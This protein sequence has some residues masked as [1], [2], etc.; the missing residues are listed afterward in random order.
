MMQESSITESSDNSFS[1]AETSKLV[2]LAWLQVR[3]CW[4]SVQRTRLDPEKTAALQTLVAH[5]R[6]VGQP[7]RPVVEFQEVLQRLE[8]EHALRLRELRRD[9]RRS[10]KYQNTRIQIVR[11]NNE[12]RLQ[13]CRNRTE[14]TP[15]LIADWKSLMVQLFG[16]S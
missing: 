4:Q 10:I 6:E 8:E 14:E 2:E 16:Q 3:M 9:E 7:D 12:A 11:D 1:S 13:H 15:P 5:Y